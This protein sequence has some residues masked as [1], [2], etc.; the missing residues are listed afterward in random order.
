MHHI[1]RKIL[2]KLLYAEALGYAQLRPEGI[3]SNHFSYHLDQ[4]VKAG[5]VAKL[6]KLYTLAPEGLKLVDR[7]SQEKMV[8]RVQPHIATVIS[9]TNSAG[10]TLLYRRG[11][12]PYIHRYSFPKGKTHYEENIQQAAER[13]LYEKAGLTDVPLT[14]RGIM[15]FESKIKGVLISKVL[16]HVFEGVTEQMPK[17]VNPQRGACEW[18]DAAAIADYEVMPGLRLVQELLATKSKD[19][20]FFTEAVE[21]MVER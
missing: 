10:Q 16:Y 19:S 1:Q 2:A 15:Y 8:E 4:L 14:H 13:E 21:E 7:L 3:E 6:D 11:F 17:D 5:L 12:Q 9:V 18:V 20:L